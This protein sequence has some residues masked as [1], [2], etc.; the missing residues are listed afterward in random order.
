[1][2]DYAASTATA[3]DFE[4]FV[5]ALGY[6]VE[7]VQGSGDSQLVAAAGDVES[8]ANAGSYDAIAAALP[9]FFSACASH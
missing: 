3:A 5:T 7:G 4:T 6:G 2:E 8:A 9:D 1:M